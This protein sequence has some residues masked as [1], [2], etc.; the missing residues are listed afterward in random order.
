MPCTKGNF[1]H[2]RF[3]NDH[4]NSLPANKISALEVMLKVPEQD[5]FNKVKVKPF[6][7]VRVENIVGLREN[8]GYILFS[9]TF[10]RVLKLRHV[11]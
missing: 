2:E 5:K 7:F 3:F 9:N 11:Q 4:R 6:A 1:S 8:D 10:C